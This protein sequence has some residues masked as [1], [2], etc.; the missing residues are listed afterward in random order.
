MGLVY[1]SLNTA[2][3]HTESI[4][5]LPHPKA[6]AKAHT[7]PPTLTRVTPHTDMLLE[8]PHRSTAMT[9]HHN[10]TAGCSKQAVASSSLQLTAGAYE[11]LPSR[12]DHQWQLGT[13]NDY[14]YLNRSGC[15][16]RKDGDDGV[17]LAGVVRLQSLVA[18]SARAWRG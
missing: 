3:R 4:P 18:H 8:G 11:P 9:N 16:D 6:G 10:F 2:L 12:T 1:G 5:S 13:V 17:M 15:V 14:H 7:A